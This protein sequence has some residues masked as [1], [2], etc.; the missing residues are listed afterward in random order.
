MM[1]NYGILTFH[2]AINYGAVLQTYALQKAMAKLDI[3]TRIIDYRCDSIENLYYHIFKG[4]SNIK[5][6]IKKILYYPVQQKRNKAFD[7]FRHKYLELSNNKY[8]KGKLKE[9]N[10]I[11]KRIIVGSDQVWNLPCT[12]EDY[13]FYLDFVKDSNAKCSY[14]ASMGKFDPESGYE[15]ALECIASFSKVSV[16]EKKALEFINSRINKDVSVLCDPTFLLDRNEWSSIAEYPE[17]EGYILVYSVNLPKTVI[18][19]ARRVAERHNK[20]VLYITLR[21]KKIE[22]NQNEEFIEACSPTEFIGYVANAYCVITNSFHGTAFSIIM[23]KDFYVI[24]NEESGL[25]NSRL[26][27]VL[28]TFDLRNQ[29][30]TMDQIA[31]NPIPCMI[32]YEKVEKLLTSEREKAMEWLQKL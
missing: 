27:T 3:K 19:A 13:T 29:E 1:N 32:D 28:T 10:T 25:D 8:Y 30:V 26:E 31:S 24:R 22:M 12:G 5:E 4:N 2:R 6:L 15:H 16:R 7:D 14:A 23:H 18:R 17:S 21:N 20:K 9:L 11:Y